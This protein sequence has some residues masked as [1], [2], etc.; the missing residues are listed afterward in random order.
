M[1]YPRRKELEIPILF[2]ISQA[3]G[4]ARASTVWANVPRHFPNLT[5][6]ELD[7][8]TEDGIR[9]WVKNIQWARLNLVKRGEIA[10]GDRGIWALT[11]EGYKR[12]RNEGRDA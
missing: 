8:R 9:K 12:L 10:N 11:Q 3:G 1:T 5:D 7:E 4:S 6:Q 2:E